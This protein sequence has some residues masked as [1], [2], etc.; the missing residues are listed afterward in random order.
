MKKLFIITLVLLLYSST[1]AQI[2]G[3]QA[4]TVI[5][6]KYDLSKYCSK[7]DTLIFATFNGSDWQTTKINKITVI[8]ANPEELFMEN[9]FADIHIKK[10]IRR[11]NK[12]IVKT[13][14]GKFRL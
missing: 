3:H 8:S 10:I 7:T 11:K 2:T 14:V 9:I 4:A 5:T 13:S 12:T 6:T 1:F